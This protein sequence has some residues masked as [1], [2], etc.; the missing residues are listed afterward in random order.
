MI[1]QEEKIAEAPTE[2]VAN[3]DIEII[4]EEQ[5]VNNYRAER[6][7]GRREGVLISLLTAGGILLLSFVILFVSDIKN[8]RLYAR[9]FQAAS[10]SQKS[11]LS[12]ETVEKAQLLESAIKLH[13][14]YDFT[15]ED[16]QA[17]LLKGIVNGL[18][19]PYSSYYTKEEYE[20]LMMDSAGELEGIGATMQ[21]DYNTGIISVVRVIEGSP[22]EKA[23]LKA[24]DII[25]KVDD[26]DIEGQDLNEVVMKIRGKAGTKVKVSVLRQGEA[27][28][29]DFEIVRD[30]IQVMTVEH[31]MKDGKIGYIQIT[32]FDDVTYEQFRKA[33]EDLKAQGMESLVLDLRSNP[34]GDVDVTVKIAN[35][36][37][38]EGIVVYT[39][40]KDKNRTDYK[41]DSQEYFEKPVA[42][43]LNGNSA[44]ASEILAGSLKDRIDAK[45]V[46]TKSFGKGIIQEIIPL[47]DG[48]G[49]KLTRF[50]YFT[51]NGN[52]IHKVGIEPDVEIEFDAEAYQKDK[53][54]KEQMMA[55]MISKSYDISD[56][57]FIMPIVSYLR[58]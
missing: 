20:E 31:E 29:V 34:G 35:M 39:E 51:P 55:D 6:K 26:E 47:G 41:S 43:L 28:L 30:R 36:F 40:D 38:K 52:V 13:Y 33:F 42:I 10:A 18:E 15:D 50:Q 57:K 11:V 46:G 8:D 2:Q 1:E 5:L 37:L 21:Q 22:A 12:K 58:E 44:S 25:R 7:K 56:R 27:D 24:D 17:G 48:S 19:D 54:E 3:D 49:I 45:I 53:T 4:T 16:L 23:G 32:E 14:L 9:F